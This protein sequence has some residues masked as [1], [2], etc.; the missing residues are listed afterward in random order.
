MCRGAGSR[1]KGASP[2]DSSRL[3][4]SSGAPRGGAQAISLTWVVGLLSS[5]KG[6]RTFCEPCRRWFRCVSGT[7]YHRRN[8]EK[9]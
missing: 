2:V 9:R 3:T 7:S 6:S 4:D 1:A 8:Y 5:P